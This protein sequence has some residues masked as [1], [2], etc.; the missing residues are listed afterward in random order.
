MNPNSDDMKGLSLSVKAKGVTLD[1]VTGI[2]YGIKARERLP[3][4]LTI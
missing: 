2:R 1:L 4:T 3:I